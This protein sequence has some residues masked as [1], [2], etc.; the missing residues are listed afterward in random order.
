MAAH[1]TWKGEQLEEASQA[2]GI[3]GTVGIDLGVNA[4]EITVREGRRRAM[5]RPRQINHVEVVFLY[6]SVEMDPY[7]RLTR[8]RSPMPEQA[9][10]DVIGL[11]RLPQQGVVAQINHAGAQI[12][13]SAPVC[14]R[15]A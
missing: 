9:I 15:A 5:P 14:I 7:E 8:V 3:V 4:F 1:A 6:Q 12:I 13:A 11:E 2:V 10:L